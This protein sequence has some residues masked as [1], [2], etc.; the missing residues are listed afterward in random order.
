MV[1]RF[2]AVLMTLVAAAASADAQQAPAAGASPPGAVSGFARNW[3]RAE[4]WDFFRPPADGGNPTYSYVANRLLFGLRRVTRRY[5]VTGAGQ[6]VQFGGLPGHATG[7]GPLGP[8][9]LYFDQSGSSDSRQLYLRYLNVRVKDLTPGLSVQLG[10]MGYT[11]GA[12]ASS[13]EASIEAVKRQRVDSR[14]IGEFEWS[15]YQ[16]GYDGVRVDWSRPAWQAT[17]AA[18]HPTQGG[19]EDAAGISI[20][21]IDLFTGTLTLRPG[22]L[23]PHTDWQLFVYRYDDRRHVRA[24]PDNT[25][26]PAD[27]VNVRINSFGTTLVGAYPR[28]PG[29]IDA[30]LWLVVQS[31][32]WYKQS[33]RAYAFAAESGYHWSHAAWQPWIR[34]GI[35]RASGDNHP[36]DTRH[37]TFFQTLPTVRKYSLSATYSQMNLSDVFVQALLRPRARL[38]LRI[39]THRLD[40]VTS[41]D[42]WYSGS[43]AT[44]AS[45]TVFGYSGRPSKGATSLGTVIEGSADYVFNRH[46]SLNG[47]VG[48][49]N[50]GAIVQ[51]TF[52]GHRLRFAY[53]ENV[54]QF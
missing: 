22:T 27:A 20:R 14:M 23:L 3:T 42:R 18:F 4:F 16:R 21:K 12:E 11:S 47:Y 53:L 1:S 51:R 33:H 30:L 28:Q 36:G 40:L 26:R 49:I 6:Y 8:G 44:Q 52:A 17:A 2:L 41:A 48:F 39:D 50:G 32:S 19:F 7:P 35:S 37:G 43:G 24:R 46:W 54:V 9:A 15:L 10:R 5:E 34:A 13:G 38:N 31:G 45:G 25:G 29:E